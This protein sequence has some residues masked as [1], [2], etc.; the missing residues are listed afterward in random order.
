MNSSSLAFLPA[1]EAL[2]LFRGGKLSPVELMH[3]VIEQA[4]A[5]EPAVN[6]LADRYFEEAIW[7]AKKAEIKYHNPKNKP[8]SLE[9]LPVAVKDDTAIQGIE[10]R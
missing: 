5:T 7:Q 1:G 9:G 10:P 3:A 4:E 6:A 2:D 8:G